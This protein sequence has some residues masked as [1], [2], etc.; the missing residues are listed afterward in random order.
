[1]EN[2]DIKTLIESFKGYRDLLN[3]I[4]TNLHDFVETYDSMK[5]DIEKLNTAFEGDIKGNLEK[6]YKNLSRQ[7]E[8][9]TDLSSRI[10]QFITMTNKYTSDVTRF[11]GLF[12]KVEERIRLVNDLE[13]KAEAQIGKLDE[14]LEEKRKNYNVKEL[15]RTLESYNA[16]VQKMSEFINK[17]IAEAL[18]QNYK[19]LDTIKS[20]NDNLTKKLKE[21]NTSVESLLNAYLTTNELLKQITEKEDVNEAYIFEIIDKWAEDRK[22]KIKK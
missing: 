6:I 17:D 14:I 18:S 22:L 4:Q 1:M 8:H 12:E 9:A 19:K 10:D 16:N 21:E 13:S 15:Q 11:V 5:N 7:A 20:G 2:N 3:P